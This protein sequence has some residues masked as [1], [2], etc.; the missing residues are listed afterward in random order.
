MN[1]T[2]TVRGA[3]LLSG[4][5]LLGGCGELT[6]GGLGE[7]EVYATANDPEAEPSASTRAVAP[8]VGDRPPIARQSAAEAEGLLIAEL[9]A[10]LRSDA[11]EEWVEI[12]DGP[13]DLTIDL[14]GR[15]ERRAG[16]RFVTAGRYSRFR[17]VFHRV[18]ADV[19]GGLI[20]DGLPILGTVTV[21]LGAQGTLTV[22]RDV[23]LDVPADGAVD[24]VLYLNAGVWLPTLSV[25][26]LTV[27]AAAFRDAVGVRV[28]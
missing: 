2:R 21:D 17:V 7:V 9:Q 16:V 1:R 27:A 5:A 19:T 6:S 14:E 28:R 8:A 22:E 20:V 4:A 25:P 12:T 3:L 15:T 10:Y 18:E 13:R 26:T 11:T 23:V 24:V